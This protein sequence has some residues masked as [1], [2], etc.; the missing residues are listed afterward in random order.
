MSSWAER[1]RGKVGAGGPS[2]AGSSS[3]DPDCGVGWAKL[4]P[5]S[6]AAVGGGVTDCMTQ[7]SSSG[8]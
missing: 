5:S 3:L 8:K 7:G 2:E 6:E 1:T 4:Q